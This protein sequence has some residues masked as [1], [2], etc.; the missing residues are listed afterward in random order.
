M[1]M[2]RQAKAE[3]VLCMWVH[4]PVRVFVCMHKRTHAHQ[5]KL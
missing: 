3:F 2:R 1:F 5:L 4:V